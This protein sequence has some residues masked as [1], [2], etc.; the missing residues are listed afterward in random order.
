MLDFRPKCSQD[1]IS[2]YSL[3]TLADKWPHDCDLP[4]VFVR[5][6]N[7]LR[8]R[9]RSVRLIYLQK[10]PNIINTNYV[11]CV[12]VSLK[13]PIAEGGKINIYVVKTDD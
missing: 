12:V 10:K 5:F 3:I 13:H 6:S 4:G 11:S 8:S 9:T 1:L 2:K 7:A